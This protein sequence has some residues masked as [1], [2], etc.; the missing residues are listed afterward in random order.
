MSKF[1]RLGTV[2]G[3][4]YRVVLRFKLG[5][6]QAAVRLDIIH[7]EDPRSH[8]AGSLGIS[9]STARMKEAIWIGLER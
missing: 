4:Q 9:A 7:D 2:L 8:A 6:K 1:Q 5:L 3:E